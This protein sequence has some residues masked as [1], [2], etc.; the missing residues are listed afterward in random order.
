MQVRR[1]DAA[2]PN[3]TVGVRLKIH[4]AK[5]SVFPLSAATRAQALQY[6]LFTG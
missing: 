3:Q 2:M 4:A 5:S 6:A 1:A